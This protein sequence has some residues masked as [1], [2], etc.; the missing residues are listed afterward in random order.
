MGRPC[1]FSQRKLDSLNLPSILQASSSSKHHPFSSRAKWWVETQRRGSRCGRCLWSLLPSNQMISWCIMM[2]MMTTSSMS[3]SLINRT[4]CWIT[5][6][7]VRP[8]SKVVSSSS[9]SSSSQLKAAHLSLDTPFRDVSQ[10]DSMRNGG[11][12]DPSNVLW[13]CYHHCKV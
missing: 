4:C 1:L 2:R 9:S 3:T 13:Q 8:T 5:L 7:W 10:T 6:L 11:T 12:S